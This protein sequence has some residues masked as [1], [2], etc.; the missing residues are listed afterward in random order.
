MRYYPVFLDLRER[1]VLLV[2][3]GAVAMRKAALLARAGA[4]LAVVAPHIDS[5]LGALADVVHARTFVADDV[6]DAAFVVAATDDAAV[7]AEVAAAARLRNIPVNVVDA[8]ALCTAILPAIVDRDPVLVAIG[9]QGAAP[10]LARRLRERIETLLDPS[11]GALAALCAR[12]RERVRARLP[13]IPL[14]RAFWERVV[15]G[16]PARALQSGQAQGAEQAVARLLDHPDRA[17]PGEVAL[18]GAGPGD[19]GLLTLHALRAIQDADVVFY[20]ALVSDEVL[21]LVRR[22]AEK[23]KVGKRGGGASVAQ[24]DIHALLLEAARRGL[25]VVRLKG[26][27]PLI[28]ARGGEELLFLHAHGVPY[29]VIPGVTAAAACAAYAGIPLT[30]REHAQAL[31]LVTAHTAESLDRLNWRALAAP[32]QTLAVYMGVSVAGGLVMRLLHAGASAST[33]VAIIE[34]GSRPEQRVILCRL[35]ELVSRIASERVKAPAL[36]VIG[37]VAALGSE[38]AWFGAPLIDTQMQPMSLPTA[39]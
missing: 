11:L 2:G 27:D 39:A 4:R 7:N 23:I 33:P 31:Q 15:D 37:S 8:P 34:N 32:N 18:V 28:F 1:R 30:H 19:P 6:I 35:D 12:W 10:V 29:R 5:A 21:E 16:A 20:D 36:L 26:G 9:T 38:L 14:R 17:A 25:R 22:D 3:G 13:T 24:A